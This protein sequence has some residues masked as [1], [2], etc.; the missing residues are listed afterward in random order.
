M[1]EYDQPEVDA[2]EQHIEDAQALTD[3]A[4]E[5]KDVCP[6]CGNQREEIHAGRWWCVFCDGSPDIYYGADEESGR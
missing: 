3:E 2:D 5:A 6:E 1:R 4:V